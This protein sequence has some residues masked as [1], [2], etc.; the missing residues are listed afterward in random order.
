MKIMSKMAGSIIEGIE[1]T[2][3]KEVKK[4]K[5]EEEKFR[6][7]MQ[8]QMVTFNKERYEKLQALGK[9]LTSGNIE[10]SKSAQRRDCCFNKRLEITKSQRYR[11]TFNK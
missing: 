11:E 3:S 8:E 2:K 5:L 4:A 9:V 1:N 7:N 10:L 6:K